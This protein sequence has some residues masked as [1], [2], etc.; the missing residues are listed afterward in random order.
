[1]TKYIKSLKILWYI[2]DIY[3]RKKKYFNTKFGI[4]IPN[5]V[6]LN[7]NYKLIK[8]KNVAERIKMKKLCDKI[9]KIL[10]VK[11]Y[12]ANL[13]NIRKQISGFEYHKYWL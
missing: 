3:L 11:K 8:N 6:F 5:R 4:G 9:L 10:L 12:K 2:W 7:Y 1:M 13:D